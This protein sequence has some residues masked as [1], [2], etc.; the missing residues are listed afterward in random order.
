MHLLNRLL[1]AADGFGGRRQK[2][3]RSL[4]HPGIGWEL[5]GEGAQEAG[6]WTLT[7]RQAR[8]PHRRH[9]LPTVGVRRHA[10]IWGVGQGCDWPHL[11]KFLQE[12]SPPCHSAVTPAVIIHVLY[13]RTH[14]HS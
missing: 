10:R 4:P 7:D 5:R 8:T 6:G 14:A 13:T 12:D 9:H 2:L 3:A 11:W 1:V